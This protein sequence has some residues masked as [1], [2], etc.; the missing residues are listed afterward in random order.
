MH[1]IAAQNRGWRE[2]YALFSKKEE[3]TLKSVIVKPKIHEFGKPWVLLR[4]REFVLN[5]FFQ[6][7]SVN[8]ISQ[9][10]QAALT[11]TNAYALKIRGALTRIYDERQPTGRATTNGS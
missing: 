2:K 8:C 5:M 11:R 3:A 10:D 9:M 1:L 4:S 7:Q 6:N